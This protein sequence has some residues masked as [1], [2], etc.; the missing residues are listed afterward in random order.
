MDEK[1]I[2]L[3]EIARRQVRVSRDR[4]DRAAQALGLL[5]EIDAAALNTSLLDLIVDCLHL[6]DR[7][8]AVVEL[9]ALLKKAADLYYLERARMDRG[10]LAQQGHPREG[11]SSSAALPAGTPED[12]QG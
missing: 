5:G 4:A 8:G 2:R 6:G 1:E 12:P 7:V 10:Y 3:A 11:G 9:E